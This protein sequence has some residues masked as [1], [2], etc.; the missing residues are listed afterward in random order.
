MSRLTHIRFRFESDHA[1][2]IVYHAGEKIAHFADGKFET[3]DRAVA[4]VLRSDG[5]CRE[6][7]AAPTPTVIQNAEAAASADASASA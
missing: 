6:V 3:K 5:L 4:E 7:H 2:L 1:N